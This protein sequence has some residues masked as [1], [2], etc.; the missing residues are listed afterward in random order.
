MTREREIFEANIIVCGNGGCYQS[1]QRHFWAK[2]RP[3]VHP[4]TPSK[5]LLLAKARTTEVFR[6]SR[7]P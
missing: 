2:F 1:P 6:H 4:G 5:R 3:D 7:T